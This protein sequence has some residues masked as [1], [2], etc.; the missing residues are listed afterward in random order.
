[1]EFYYSCFRF[2]LEQFLK[3]PVE[4]YNNPA[5]TPDFEKKIE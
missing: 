4:G 2:H 3:A 5:F 1:M